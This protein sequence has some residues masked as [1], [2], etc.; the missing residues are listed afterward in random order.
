MPATACPTRPR[1]GRTAQ[2]LLAAL[3][4]LA[5]ALAVAQPGLYGPE[6]PSGAAWLRVV[7]VAAPG[8]IGVRVADDATVVLPLGGATRYVQVTAGDVLVDVGGEPIVVAVGPETFTT[9]AATAAGLVVVTD[10]A[11]RDASRGLLGLMNLTTH[12]ALDLRV[13]DG[14]RVVAA[15]PPL[16]HAALAVARATSALLVTDG[17]RVL[18]RLGPHTFERGVAYVVIVFDT[19]DGLAARLLA[20]AAD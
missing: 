4:A 6:A 2:A 17:E 20:S 9:V 8:G 13:P 14:G 12:E 3:A 1:A 18:L 16:A 11:L 10:P 5:L 19:A 15:V 7:N